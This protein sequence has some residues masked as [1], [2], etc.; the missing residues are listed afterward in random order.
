MNDITRTGGGRQEFAGD[1]PSGGFHTKGISQTRNFT[2]LFRARQPFLHHCTS[3]CPFL[4][5]AT[6]EVCRQAILSNPWQALPVLIPVMSCTDGWLHD[7][8][9]TW[10]L[11]IPQSF[12]QQF[13]HRNG[14]KWLNYEVT[15]KKKSSVK[16]IKIPSLIY[17]H[18]YNYLLQKLGF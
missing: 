9:K 6:K 15:I 18:N 12:T 13:S 10:S 14:L 2:A 5:N 7:E 8:I 16:R 11:L 1:T 3:H 4:Q 17:H